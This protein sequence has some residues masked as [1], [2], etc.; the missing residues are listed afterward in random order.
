MRGPRFELGFPRW[1]RGVL[2]LEQP[3]PSLEFSVRLDYLFVEVHL[4]QFIDSVIIEHTDETITGLAMNVDRI[5]RVLESKC[6]VVEQVFDDYETHVSGELLVH[7]FILDEGLEPPS[8]ARKAKRIAK[9][10]VST[11]PIQRKIQALCREV[12]ISFKEGNGT[13]LNI[14]TQTT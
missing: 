11:T 5:T 7:F 13:D 2:P 8:L 6:I 12:T 10:R 3:H 1:K 9:R 14:G 4:S